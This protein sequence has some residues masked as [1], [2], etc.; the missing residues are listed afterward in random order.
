MQV[1]TCRKKGSMVYFIVA[2]DFDKR[3]VDKR[4]LE[5]IEKVVPIVKK[6]PG[7]L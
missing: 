1:H 5:Y 7:R 2:V 3:R 6:Y 4:Y